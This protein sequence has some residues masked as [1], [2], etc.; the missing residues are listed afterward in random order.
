MFSFCFKKKIF[1]SAHGTYI[2]H[3]R[4]ESRKPQQIPIDS[5]LHFGA[6]TRI[7]TIRERPQNIGQGDEPEKQG[8]KDGNLLGLPENETELDVRYHFF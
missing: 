7:Y 6:S 1:I 3:I 2:G 8:E 4:L 5:E